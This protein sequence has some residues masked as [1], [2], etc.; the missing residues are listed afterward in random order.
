MGLASLSPVRAANAGADLHLKHPATGE[1]LFET[2]KG[3]QVPAT[4]LLYG[5]DSAAVKEATKLVEQ[6]RAKGE[7]ITPEDA[8]IL[9]L[10]AAIGGWSA[11][12][13]ISK[14]GDIPFTPENARI[15]LTNPDTA[16][17]AEQ[18]GPFSMSRRNFPP[19]AG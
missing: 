6:R 9:I 18:I 19:K 4:I 12:I 16:W 14:A 10:T 15:L 2:V 3:K 5:R 1:P 8:G 13:G 11:A 7:D 17:V